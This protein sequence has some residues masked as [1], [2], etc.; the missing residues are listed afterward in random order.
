MLKKSVVIYGAGNQGM[1]AIEK[2][3]IMGIH[4]VE[5]A[6]KQVGK[7]CGRFCSISIE[8]LCDRADN[9]VCVITPNLPLPDVWKKPQCSYSVVIDFLTVLEIFN[10]REYF[11]SNLCSE[12]NYTLCHPFNCYDSPY[13]QDIEMV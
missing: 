9:E 12:M 13:I 7:S 4:I 5:I 2:F 8:T 3:E 10:V 1:A 11:F 6:D